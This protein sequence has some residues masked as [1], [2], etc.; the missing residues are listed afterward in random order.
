MT[1]ELDDDLAYK[2][3]HDFP[4]FARLC[5]K[6]E[7]KKGKLEPFELNDAQWIIWREIKRQMDAKLPVRVIILKGRQ[8]GCSTLA[9]GIAMWLACTREGF[10]GMTIAHKLKPAAQELF[11]KVELMYE[12]LP[13]EVKVPLAP[14]RATGRRLKFDAPLRSLLVVE[15]AE[16]SDAVG[17]S[18]T[19]TFGHLTEIPFWKDPE[20]TIAAFEA[21]V[22]NEPET[23]IIVESTAQGMGNWFHR[24]WDESERAV[25]DQRQ[26]PYWPVFVPWFKQAEYRRA[27]TDFDTDLTQRERERMKRFDLDIEQV[28]WFR[29][30]EQKNGDLAQQEYPDTPRDAFL[31][32]GM[33]FFMAKPLAR[34]EEH[35]KSK[36]PVRKGRWQVR[37]ERGKTKAAFVENRMGELWVWDTPRK[38]HHYVVSVDPSSGRAKDRSAYHVLDVTEP[39]IRQVASFHGML[40]PDELAIDSITTCRYY[41]N[42]L[43]VPERNAVGERLVGKGYDDIGYTN[44]YR[45]RPDAMVGGKKASPIAGWISSPKTRPWAVEKLAEAVHNDLIEINCTRTIEEM[46]SFV[47]LDAG[48]KKMGAADGAHDDL[49]MA[50]A[51]GVA[52][53]DQAGGE[54]GYE[55]WVS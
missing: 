13:D 17:R 37:R 48:E 4:T 47:Y 49:V 54:V 35:A 31:S 29:D 44:V 28:L 12:N 33:P 34:H 32:S 15:S 3:Y 22:P 5:L 30:K 45:F 18:G 38:G 43:W 19:F 24:T 25:R 9:Q 52:A 1:D 27:K 20:S 42:A 39:V 14:G 6:I 23:F 41:N 11:G 51:I 53:R 55:R 50:L 8:Q 46:R 16:E 10:K 21:C 26:P 36:P 40:Q 7:T 2:L